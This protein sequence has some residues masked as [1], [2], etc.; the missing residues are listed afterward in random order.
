MAE[1]KEGAKKG[2]KMPVI[3]AAVL[4]LAGG[5]YFMMSKGKSSEPQKQPDV[6]LGEKMDLGEFV[7]PL[8]DGKT[9]L[10]VQVVVQ[11]GKDEHVGEAAGGEHSG[12][13][14][15]DPLARN[16]V[17]TV[18]RDTGPED[19]QTNE[20][21]SVLRQRIAWQINHDVEVAE[22]FAPPKEGGGKKRKKKKGEAEKFEVLPV[23]EREYPEL[24]S[25]DGPVRIVM[26]TKFLP[27]DYSN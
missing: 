10:Q 2:S 4:V 12:A 27:V 24:D 13:A 19:I 11:L 25:D 5:G 16:A 26:F 23:K 22:S 3:I 9:F 6:I 1:A 7:T 14:A 20:K 17:L 18:L 21:L 15:P 8:K